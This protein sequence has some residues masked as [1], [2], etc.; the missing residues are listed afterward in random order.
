MLK[1]ISLLSAGVSSGA[2]ISDSNITRNIAQEG[3]SKDLASKAVEQLLAAQERRARRG[4]KLVS[5]ANA[6]AA[7]VSPVAADGL[8]KLAAMAG[9]PAPS[10]AEQEKKHGE[11]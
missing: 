7:S 1:L 10:K 6:P 3:V 11:A 9:P 4:G 5:T 8:A 2:L